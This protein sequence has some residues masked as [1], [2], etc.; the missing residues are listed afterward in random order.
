M[1]GHLRRPLR[2]GA[3]GLSLAFTI[4][5][6][7]STQPQA[8]STPVVGL[9]A[10]VFHNPA[11]NPA[12]DAMVDIFD[13]KAL[14][15]DA[16]NQVMSVG[17][18]S[19]DAATL[20]ELLN[21][22]DPSNS[23]FH[24]NY[25]FDARANVQVLTVFTDG[26]AQVKHDAKSSVDESGGVTCTGAMMCRTDPHTQTTT[27][28]YPD[29]VVAV[30]EHLNDIATTAKSLGAAV[31]GHLNPVTD[32]TPAPQAAPAAEPTLEPAPES[33]LD[34]VDPP[35][36]PAARTGPRLNVIRP[37]PD[38]S[39][40]RS[41]PAPASPGVSTD[42]SETTDKFV[43]DVLTRVNDTVNRLFNPNKAP[44]GRGGLGGPPPAAE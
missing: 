13:Y 11:A 23:V 35:T 34:A 41:G 4:M 25:E 21:T 5:V 33:A 20:A 1:L 16:D 42:L 17:G 10:F 38:F 3:A 8:V 6:L 37:A 29:G 24:V 32:T 27:I 19:D 43:N 40:G 31:L 26:N 39:P 22:T 9:A 12:G 14:H 15:T 44:T 2:A 28:T 30:V 7:A 36:A 18:G